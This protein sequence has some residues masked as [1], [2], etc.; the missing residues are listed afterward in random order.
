MEASRPTPRQTKI[1]TITMVSDESIPNTLQIAYPL[2]YNT[3]NLCRLVS[4][5]ILEQT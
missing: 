5:L 1:T 3:I 4:Y 2:T